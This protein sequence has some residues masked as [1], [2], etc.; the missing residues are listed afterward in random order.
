M[1]HTKVVDELVS[2]IAGRRIVALTGAGMSTA[3]GIPDYR[4]PESSKR[5]RNPIQYKEFVNSEEAR[6]RYWA[7]SSIGWPRFTQARANP[8][9]EAL[10]T[11]EQVGYLQG[12]ITQN[13]DRLHQQAGSQ[14]VVELHGALEEVRCLSCGTLEARS[15]LQER[16]LQLNPGWEASPESYAPDGD[17]EIAPSQTRNFQVPPCQE[18]GGVLKP[19]VVFFGENV[20]RSIVDQAWTLVDEAEVLLVLGSSLTVFSGYRFVREAEQR[21]IP[22]IIINK[23]ETR[24]DPHANLKIH[25]DVNELLPQLVQSLLPFV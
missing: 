2:R 4:G 16:L 14:R 21:G 18:C 8:G 20:A 25:A 24:G 3:S 17:A 22:V 15:Q 5:K 6:S 10:A 7:R 19:N 11:L 12:I 1:D 9:H 23:G 13:V